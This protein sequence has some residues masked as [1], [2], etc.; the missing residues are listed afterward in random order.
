MITWGLSPMLYQEYS[1]FASNEGMLFYLKL[2][3][4]FARR[5]CDFYKI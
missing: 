3:G 4:G 2:L 1:L 5:S